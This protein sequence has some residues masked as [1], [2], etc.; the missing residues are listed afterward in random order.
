MISATGILVEI[1]NGKVINQ[2]DIVALAILDI[3]GISTPNFF[4][5]AVS[6][7]GNL[8]YHD[9][10]SLGPFFRIAEL[11]GKKYYQE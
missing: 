8:I 10:N 3:P 5:L 7:D 1:K 2:F 11:N 4:V 9:I 6:E